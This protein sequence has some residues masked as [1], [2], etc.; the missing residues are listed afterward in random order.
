MAD[1]EKKYLDEAGA[2]VLV[3]Q[4]KEQDA[5][6]LSE[7]KKYTDDEIAKV[8]ITSGG[9][10]ERLEVVEGAI[11]VINGEE[12]VVGS[13]AKVAKDASDAIAAE[14]ERAEAVE[15]GLQNSIDAINDG[16]TGILK[17]AK[18]Y[19]DG[20]DEA[21]A[22]AKKAGDDAQA[23]V[24]ALEALVGTVAEGKTVMGEIDTIN[25]KLD[26]VE[27]GAQVNIIETVKFNGIALEVTEKSVDVVIPN[28]TQNLSYAQIMNPDATEENPYH[29]SSDKEVTSSYL[30]SQLSRILPNIISQ[31]DG[32]FDIASNI[33]YKTVETY[34]ELEAVDISG[35]TNGIYIYLVKK[36]ENYPRFYEKDE[37]GNNTDVVSQYYTTIYIY[38]STQP[39]TGFNFIGKLNVS[40]E[41]LANS[42][43]E[44]IHKALMTT[45]TNP[46]TNEEVEVTKFYTRT[47]G[48]A[49]AKSV[50]DEVTR[51]TDAES[52][53]N[54]RITE[55]EAKFTGDDS[56]DNKIATAKSEAISAASEDAT[57]K[58]AT[59][60]QNAKDYADELNSNMNTRVEALEAVKWV[61][62][63]E[64]E[65]KALFADSAK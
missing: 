39:E 7:A 64:T 13:L 24:D 59:A 44:A 34:A 65:I 38:L 46:E 53:L 29:G 3:E 12:T 20:K 55:L 1:I 11:E 62:L 5:A 42:T 6:K 43:S 30:Y 18:D 61:A 58:A 54:T 60:E 15:N 19:A 33:Q 21:I 8:N 32:I 37:N 36:D 35:L 23:D 10:N 50:S 41:L 17:S 40:E 45:V 31:V 63:T 48:E 2:A 47:E 49:V 22:A 52:G 25:T 27:E 14:K 16:E 4:I 9:I 28:E 57:T 26:T 51:A 56:V